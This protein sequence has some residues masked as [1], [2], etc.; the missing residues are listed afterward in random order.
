MAESIPLSCP[1]CAGQPRVTSVLRDGYAKHQDDPAARAYFYTCKSCAAS[2][3]W[4]KS[5]GTALTYWNM[6]TGLV[7]ELEAQKTKNIVIGEDGRCQCSCA[8]VCPLG[9]AGSMMRCTET[10]LRSAGKL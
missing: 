1:F 10:E 8:D 4:G 7:V 9:R 3:G 6:R 5:E 2:G